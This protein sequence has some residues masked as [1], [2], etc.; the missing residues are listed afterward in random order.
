MADR[1]GAGW[2]RLFLGIPVPAVD[3]LQELR[4]V[5]LTLT[6][7][8]GA[9]MRMVAPPDLH[10]TLKFLGKVADPRVPDVTRVMAQVVRQWPSLA[11]SL[12]GVGAFG[13]AIWV[14]VREPVDLP[15]TGL[16]AELDRQMGLAGFAEET[17]PY[18]PHLTV[19]RLA[20]GASVPLPE[21]QARFGERHWG[22]LPVNQV[23]LYASRTLPTGARYTVLETVYLA[24]TRA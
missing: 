15:L 5:L 24:G 13:N 12:E 3:S 4:Q 6:A 17:R 9:A 18:R 20:P 16:A 14:G 11:L 22:K 10:I 2:Q 1:N 8:N 21:L 19:A 23:H 7:E